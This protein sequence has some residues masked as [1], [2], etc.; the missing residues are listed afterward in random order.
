MKWEVS[1]T[2]L[3][4][5]LGSI[6][7]AP[8]LGKII[9]H[10][11]IL[12][13]S[14]DRNPGTTNAFEQG[15]FLCGILTLIC[16][17]GKG[18]LPVF[19]YLKVSSLAGGTTI[20]TLGLAIVMAAPVLGHDF[21][22]YHRF[23]GGKGIA[24]TFGCLL[25]FLPDVRPAAI[26]AVVF[27]LFSVVIRITPHFYR[28]IATYVSAVFIFLFWGQMPAQKLGFLLIALIVCVRMHLSTEEREAC[29]VR[30]LWMR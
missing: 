25:A 15:G 16:D 6:L 17:I 13:D 10:K 2:I 12:Q 14:K 3:G 24:T 4:Y 18:F 23:E 5:L 21:S 8:F 22:L 28:T 9:A 19:L 1:F 11:D 26:L 30:L 7:F 27:I 29:R 20:H